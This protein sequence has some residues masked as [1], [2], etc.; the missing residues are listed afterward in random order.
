MLAALSILLG[1]CSKN[2]ADNNPANA[3]NNQV[4]ASSS[5][6]TNANNQS[7]GQ[8]TIINGSDKNIVKV[9]STGFR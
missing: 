7:G 1:S 4:V 3:V 5:N 2:V 6:S 8:V 9:R